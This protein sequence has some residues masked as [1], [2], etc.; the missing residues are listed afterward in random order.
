MLVN[1]GWGPILVMALI[2][3]V[4]ILCVVGYFASKGQE[5]LPPPQPDTRDFAYRDYKGQRYDRR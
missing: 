2:L 4:L 3:L 1:W 5:Y